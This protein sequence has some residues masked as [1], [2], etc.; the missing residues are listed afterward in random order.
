MTFATE[1]LVTAR[2]AHKCG[3]CFRPIVKG[4]QYH[5]GAGKWEGDFWHMKW[6]VPCQKFRTILLYVDGEFWNDCYGGISSWVEN[7]GAQ[8]L[9]SDGFSWTFRLHVARLSSLFRQHW[10]GLTT[11]IEHAQAAMQLEK[12]ERALKSREQLRRAAG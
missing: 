9:E 12:H 3:E 2:K 6:C 1:K 4:E 7:V 8:E 5:R 10:A 11:E